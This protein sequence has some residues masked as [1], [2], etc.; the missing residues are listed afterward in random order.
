MTPGLMVRTGA[1]FAAL[2]V[3]LGAFAAHALKDHLEPPALATIETGVRYQMYHGLALVLCAAL[4]AVGGGTG[5]NVRIAAI[6]FAVGIVFFS[7]SLY[8]LALLGWKWLGPVTPL[9]GTAFLVG[10]LAL[11]VGG[12]RGETRRSP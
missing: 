3:A 2:A 11:A 6:A 1:T 9:G 5:R 4:A 12:L 8:G 7:G 10:W